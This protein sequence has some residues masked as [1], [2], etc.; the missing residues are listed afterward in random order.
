MTWRWM[1]N[2]K[3][4]QESRLVI[5]DTGNGRCPRTGAE[6]GRRLDIGFRGVK[7]RGI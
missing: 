3:T 2:E 4:A 1:H 7:R 6:R 5:G